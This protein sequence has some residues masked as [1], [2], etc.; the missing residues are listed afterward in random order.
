VQRYLFFVCQKDASYD[1]FIDSLLAQSVGELC[2]PKATHVR[3][4]VLKWFQSINP[5]FPSC[6]A[7]KFDSN[8]TWH[9]GC[10]MKISIKS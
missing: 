5:A 10:Q 2:T 7:Q 9:Q 8:T 1:V 6:I 3:F 4:A